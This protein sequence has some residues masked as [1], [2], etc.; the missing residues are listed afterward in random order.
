MSSWEALFAS[1]ECELACLSP[2]IFVVLCVYQKVGRRVEHHLSKTRP[3]Q[4]Q[5]GSSS[6]FRLRVVIFSGHR[7]SSTGHVPLSARSHVAWFGNPRTKLLELSYD[8]SDQQADM[9][10]RP[11]LAFWGSSSCCY[12]APFPGFMCFLAEARP[13]ECLSHRA[14]G[15]HTPGF[16]MVV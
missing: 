12:R 6:L 10:P 1:L 11:P 15:Y 7:G 9:L 13:L 3:L 8:E 14:D 16:G 2:S 5:G 4:S